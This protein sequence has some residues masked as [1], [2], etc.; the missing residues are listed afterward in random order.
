MSFNQAERELLAR[1]A[2][3][4][5]PA[6]GGHPSASD[7]DVAG[8]GLDLVLATCPETCN[9]PARRACTRRQAVTP[10]EAVARVAIQ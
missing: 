4:L 3:V 2:D 5:I 9:R 6:G 8:N 10:A 1:L 7:A